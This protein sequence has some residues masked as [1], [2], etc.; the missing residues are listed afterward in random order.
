MPTELDKN[1]NYV[2]QQRGILP[3]K[4]ALSQTVF[5]ST[6]EKAGIE[7]KFWYG[8]LD[9]DSITNLKLIIMLRWTVI[10]LVVAIIAAVFGFGGIAASAAGIAKVLFFIFIVLFL[11]SLIAGRKS[12]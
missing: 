11:I 12:V 2:D 6:I 10:F 9:S 8:F 5:L 1:Y 3:T 7:N 4:S